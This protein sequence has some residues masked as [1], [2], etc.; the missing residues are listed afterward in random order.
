M[1]KKAHRLD[2]MRGLYRFEE[3]ELAITLVRAPIEATAQA[4]VDHVHARRWERDLYDKPVLVE[5]SSFWVPF[6]LEG[7]CWTTMIDDTRSADAELA[8]A[9]ALSAALKTEAIFY[10]GNDVSGAWVCQLYKSGRLV[11]SVANDSGSGSTLEELNALLEAHDALLFYDVGFG[12]P[13]GKMAGFSLAPAAARR[14][15]VVRAD[16]IALEP[17]RKV[18]AEQLE[19]E[20]QANRAVDECNEAFVTA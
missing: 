8:H 6:Q 15:K 14:G 13:P 5:G 4:L 17:A 20:R 10:A 11:Q 7:H 9:K 2:T 1:A 12:M 3:P 16:L 19:A 18:S